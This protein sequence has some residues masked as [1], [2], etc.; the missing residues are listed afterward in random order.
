MKIEHFLLVFLILLPIYYLLVTR[1][2]HGVTK[3]K[4]RVKNEQ[5][6]RGEETLALYAKLY[7]IF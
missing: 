1:F 3:S 7:I 5:F 6:N 4:I 2:L